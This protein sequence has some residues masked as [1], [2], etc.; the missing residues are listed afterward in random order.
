MRGFRGKLDAKGHAEAFAPA[1]V[2]TQ[3]K[4]L[5]ALAILFEDADSLQTASLAS[6]PVTIK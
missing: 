4:E 3:A 2:L 1:H 6:L 5:T